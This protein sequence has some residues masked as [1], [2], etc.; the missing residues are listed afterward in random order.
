MPDAPN[1]ASL[2]VERLAK[3]SLG[4]TLWD[5][6]VRGLCARRQRSKAVTFY[7]KYRTQGRRTRWYKIG[8]WKSPWQ[9]G[10][11]RDEA[12]KVL[13]EVASGHDPQAGRES[14]RREMTV[15]DVLTAY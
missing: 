9:P 11:A 3:L 4:E 5:T 1:R 6:S 12:L 13:G 14:K 2:T 7:V 8:Q 10:T 15:A